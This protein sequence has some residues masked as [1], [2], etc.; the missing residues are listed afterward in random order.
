M[1]VSLLV[2]VCIALIVLWAISIV[3]LPP[4]AQM[5]RPILYIIVAVILIVYLLRFIQ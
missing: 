3:P 2:V 1:L 4:N 5:V